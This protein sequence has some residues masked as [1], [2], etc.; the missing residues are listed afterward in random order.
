M[1]GAERKRLRVSLSRYRQ[2]LALEPEHLG[3]LEQLARISL[4]LGKPKRAVEYLLR[5]AEV[6]ARSAEFDTALADCDSALQLAPKHAPTR[7]LREVIVQIIERHRASALVQ[8]ERGAP[9]AER[10]LPK[11]APPTRPIEPEASDLSMPARPYDPP[12]LDIEPMTVEPDGFI[13]DSVE[14][15][16]GPVVDAAALL[17]VYEVDGVDVVPIPTEA[18][19]QPRLP[20]LRPP[21]EVHAAVDT[22][23]SEAPASVSG[24][25]YGEALAPGIDERA[26]LDFEPDTVPP[27]A[28]PRVSRAP[29][30]PSLNTLDD[31]APQLIDTRQVEGVVH[32]STV[33]PGPAVAV[34][35]S[36]LLQALPR[37]TRSDLVR[38]CGRIR[39]AAGDAL[40]QPGTRCEGI[41]VVVYG[42]VD[43]MRQAGERADRVASLRAGDLLGDMEHLHGGRWQFE[44]VATEACE[45]LRI[46]AQ[47]VAEL[48]RQF[49]A[50]EALLRASANRRHAAWLLGANPMFRVLGPNERDL[51][52]RRLIERHFEPDA[53]VC[54]EGERLNGIGLVATGVLHVSRGGQPVARLGPGRFAGL[55]AL[56]RDGHSS[57]RIAAGARGATVY[58]LDH[59]A[60]E[61]LC[62]FPAIRDLFE[63]AGRQRA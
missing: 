2:L 28:G 29:T 25:G 52:A 26:T 22:L 33:A 7:R 30:N 1:H 12:T 13:D 23:V 57:A 11:L 9:Q 35:E 42:A 39:A 19:A 32:L 38:V 3:H 15:L 36:P 56:G 63:A 54:V 20:I 24:Q 60:V 14:N 48:R 62:R 55:G 31:V 53:V 47:L 10:A 6:C 16:P 45:L 40:T 49:P 50:F 37:G 18:P 5:R 17:A 43:L 58:R 61:D 34:P 46:D 41:F 44:A 51:I 21:A 4:A 27:G 59:A 8:P